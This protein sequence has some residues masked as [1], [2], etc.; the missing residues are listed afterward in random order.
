MNTNDIQLWAYYRASNTESIEERHTE[1]MGNMAQIGPPIGFAELDQLPR[2]PDCGTQLSAD[3][4]GTYPLR[5]LRFHGSYVYRGPHYKYSDKA[6][7]DDNFRIS[8]KTSKTSVDYRAILHEHFPKVLRAFRAYRAIV[9]YDAYESAY[10]YGY[11]PS[12]D[13]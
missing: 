4:W 1:F 7:F 6:L 9:G 11:E 2:A 8:F 3:Y 5:G 13:G 12:S 10:C